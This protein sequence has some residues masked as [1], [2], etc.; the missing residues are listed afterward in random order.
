MNPPVQNDSKPASLEYTKMLFLVSHGLQTPLSAIRW[1]CS[2]LSK[3][4][5]NLT[6]EQWR[7]VEGMQH[8]TRML[9]QMFDSLLLLAKVE[10]GVQAS[11]LQDIYLSDYFEGAE[12]LKGMPRDYILDMTCPA[13]AVVKVDRIIFTSIMDA[14]FLVLSISSTQTTIPLTV[15]MEEG[16]CVITLRAPME[17]S[18]LQEEGAPT[19]SGKPQRIVGGI[20]GFLL[21]V[22]ASSAQHIGGTLVS[23]REEIPST[24]TL[25]FPTEPALTL[26]M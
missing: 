20:P 6:P 7:L 17:L 15:T 21:A 9:S 3:T 13:D 14:L 1:G 11:T 5:K 8:Q 2:R 16:E 24:L 4:G 12:L 26:E 18:F 19:T 10:E 23:G 25:R 22:S